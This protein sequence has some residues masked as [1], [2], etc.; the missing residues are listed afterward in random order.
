VLL[1][2]IESLVAAATGPTGLALIFVYSV[3]VAVVLPL[4]GELVL[5]PAPGLALGVSPTVSI[6][7]VI[8]VSAVGKAIGSVWA[9]RIGRGA[10]SAGPSQWLRRRLLPGRSPWGGQGRLRRFVRRYEYLGL[11]TLLSIPLMPDTAVVYAFSVLDGDERRFALAA[12]A[13]TVARLCITL[14][15]AA[16]VL[17]TVSL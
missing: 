7:L 4:P 5:L 10:L 14:A 16:G 1:E 15:L 11:A 9:L 3:L 12:F 6:A 8:F 13:G 2:A 17:A